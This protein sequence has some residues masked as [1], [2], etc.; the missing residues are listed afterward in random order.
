MCWKTIESYLK[1][2]PM[3]LAA[4]ARLCRITQNT[5]VNYKKGG[6]ISRKAAMKIER[7]TGLKYESL[8]TY[9]KR[10]RKIYPE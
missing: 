3:S 2:H 7:A 4:F 8:T 10:I 5:V 9:P 1:A 6:N